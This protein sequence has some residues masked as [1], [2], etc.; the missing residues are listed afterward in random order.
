MEHYIANEEKDLNAITM[1]QNKHNVA[2]SYNG[3][4]LQLK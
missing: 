2:Y 4:L 1:E 3:T